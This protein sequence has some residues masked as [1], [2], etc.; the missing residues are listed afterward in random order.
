[1]ETFVASSVLETTE[2]HAWEAGLA[3]R[4][5]VPPGM[6]VREDPHVPEVFY[7]ESSLAAPD[8]A[9]AIELAARVAVAVAAAAGVP[10][11][12]DEVVVIGAC[13]VTRWAADVDAAVGS[14]DSSSS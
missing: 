8:A 1:M 10:M 9:G 12:L 6:S 11:V 5:D 3:L 13:G 14:V 2:A 7:L 4:V